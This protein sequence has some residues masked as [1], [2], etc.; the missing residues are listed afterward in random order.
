M[1]QIVGG[2]RN[3]KGVMKYRNGRQYEGDWVD[4]IREGKGFER[5]PN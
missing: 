5:Y 1:G 3:G 2:K 4:D